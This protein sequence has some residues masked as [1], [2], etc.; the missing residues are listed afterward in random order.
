[1][2][3]NMKKKILMFLKEQQGFVSG[4]DICETL[5]IS[6]TA[7]WKYINKLKEEGYEIESVTRKGYRLLQSPDFMTVE[8]LNRYLPEGTLAGD[9]FYYDS[10]DSTNEEAKRK[11]AQGAPDE[12]LCFADNQT[13]G[14]GRR[15]RRWISPKGEDIF[16]SLLLRPELPVESASMLTLVAALAAAAVSERYSGEACGIKWPNDIVLHNKKIC[17]ILTEMGLEMNDISYIVVGVGFN[18]NRAEFSEDISDMATSLCRETGKKIPRARFLA[19]FLI[20]FMSRYRKF[21]KEQNL[22][23][24]VEE[25][26]SRL[27]NI[28][29][30][31][32]IIRKGQE[33]IQ[34][35]IGI[36]EKGELIVQKEN[37]ELE[38]VFTGEVS[39]RGLYGY[40]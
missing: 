16:F 27:V 39:V 1:M 22:V 33:E 10:I 14:K 32:K 24:F 40:V 9:I 28:G 2:A 25:Y 13:A 38:T 17:G 37:G 8:E 5:G 20:E 30:K 34:T 12:S 21:L 19:D 3:D 6:R 31:V 35:A 7:V 11:A 36:N 26:E 4:Q 15:G 29:R 18:V 23:S